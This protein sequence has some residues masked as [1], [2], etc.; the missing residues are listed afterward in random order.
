VN[1]RNGTWETHGRSSRGAGVPLAAVLRQTMLWASRRGSIKRA[2]TAAPITRE[3]VR[4][5]VAG[6]DVGDAVAA[7]R[8]LRE[9]GLRCTLDFL[10]EDTRDAQMAT[11]TVAAY[12]TLL[13]R[14]AAEG[15]A[16][17]AEVSVKL[18]ALGQALDEGM[19]FDNAAAVCEAARGAG[20]TVTIDMEDHTTTDS[21]LSILQRLRADYPSTGAVIQAS[22]RRSPAD[23][24]ALAHP[25]SR[26]RLCKGA[27]QEPASVAWQTRSEIRTAYIRCLQTLVAGGAYPM[28]ATHDP[29]LI[30]VSQ[31]VLQHPA[32]NGDGHEFQMLFGIRPQE[33]LRLAA[34]GELMRIY[35]PFGTQWY[36]YLMRRMAERPANLALVLRA[37][38]SRN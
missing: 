29:L 5:F 15:L 32:R 14:L 28:L 33:Q 12:R 19:A 25:G 1:A 16:A 9:K 30:R 8:G 10:G 24:A 7:A 26:V 13:E 3:V 23:C 38:S 2:V 34:N 21:T 22:L 18:S 35:V 11:A 36:G 6:E 4:R 31:R 17:S 20:T 27:Y 37:L